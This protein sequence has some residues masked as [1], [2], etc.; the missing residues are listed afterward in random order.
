MPKTIKVEFKVALRGGRERGERG[1]KNEHDFMDTLNGYCL[2][3]FVY[4]GGTLR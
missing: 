2:L 3:R 4:C 1:E